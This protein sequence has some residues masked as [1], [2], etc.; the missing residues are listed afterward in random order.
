MMTAFI[1]SNFI[2]NPYL[3]LLFNI[4]SFHDVWDKFIFSGTIILR[5]KL[6]F[7]MKECSVI[8]IKYSVLVL[9]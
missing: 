7:T 9:Y 5:I 2:L 1:K 8:Y 4:E 3:L 6:G